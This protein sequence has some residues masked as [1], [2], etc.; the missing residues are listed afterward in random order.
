MCVCVCA[1][2]VKR[3]QAEETSKTATEPPSREVKRPPDLSLSSSIYISLYVCVCVCVCVR[4]EAAASGRNEQGSYGTAEPR[5]EAEYLSIYLRS[6]V[7]LSMHVCVCVCA[8]AVRLR[9]A[10]TSRAATEP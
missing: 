6:S 1:R 2:A 3:R 8:R 9:A 7:F 10:E 4:S 5:G